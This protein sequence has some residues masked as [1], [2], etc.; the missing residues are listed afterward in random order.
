MARNA[1]LPKHLPV[2]T[3]YIVEGR[4]GAKG[5]RVSARYVLLPNGRRL[6]L[7]AEKAASRT[8]SARRRRNYRF[9][10]GQAEQAAPLGV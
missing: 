1:R 2:G 9:A 10:R 8:R 5:F 3:R 7:P 4:T 6:D